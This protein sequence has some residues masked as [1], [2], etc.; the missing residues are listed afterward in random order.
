M[1]EKKFWIDKLNEIT[2]PITIMEV[3]GSH[4]HAISKEGIRQ[5]LPR[6][7]RLISGPGCPV[8]V[9]PAFYIDYLYYLGLEKGV[10]IAT[11]GDLI[12]I[13]GSSPSITL[14]RARAQGAKVEMVL[15]S[16]EVL[17]L[18]EKH[19]DVPIV[20]AALGFETTAPA[21]AVLIKE[22]KHRNAK[23]IYVLCVHKVMR[24]VMEELLKDSNLKL[25]GF[26]CPGHVAAITGSDYFDFISNYGAAGVVAGFSGDEILRGIYNCTSM[27]IKKEA[28]IIN[29]YESLVKPEGNLVALKLMNEVFEAQGDFWR[30]LGYI[31]KSGLR[32]RE[33]YSSFDITK[34]FEM[35]EKSCEE[36]NTCC[37]GSVLKGLLSPEQCP[38]FSTICNPAN[39]LGPCMVSSEGSCAAAYRYNRG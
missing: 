14:E 26:L 36:N 2:E 30:G 33:E 38:N 37:C 25:Q 28:G 16:M 19:K 8:C 20:F 7:I 23:N 35:K 6:N 18:G 29:C 22:L 21:T 32:L 12:R 24:P 1:N 27:V 3:C 34:L 10:V 17:R 15:S 4:T 5:V 39:P 11:Y 31:P 9:T 13:P